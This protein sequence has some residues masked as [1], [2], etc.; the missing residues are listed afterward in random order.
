MD[1]VKQYDYSRCHICNIEIPKNTRLHLGY[2][3]RDHHSEWITEEY[4]K[5]FFYNNK[6]PLCKCGCQQETKW[7]KTKYKYSDYLWGHQSRDIEFKKIHEP[8]RLL[9]LKNKKSKHKKY[10]ECI[11][12]INSTAKT[13]QTGAQCENQKIYDCKTKTMIA[14]SRYEDIAP[15]VKK[16]HYAKYIGG[17][18]NICF[19]WYDSNDELYA[20]AIYGFP[21]NNHN[22]IS[23]LRNIVKDANIRKNNT[24]ELRRLCR[25]EPKTDSM[26]LTKFISRC[27][28]LLKLHRG[29]HYILSFSDPEYSHSGGI[30]RAANFQH[31]GKS[32]S[33]N[34]VQDQDGN[35]RHSRFVY[36]YAKKNSMSM[37]E[38]L[39]VMQCTRYKTA[40]KDR[41]FIK[42]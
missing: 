35:I 17:S 12:D 5:Q 30:Y 39:E 32:N 10:L 18:G 16:W 15:F 4:Y 25:R 7:Q 11:S 21:T 26:P 3:L 14:I 33:N 38:A 31:I 36:Q 42:T 6:I 29:I 41:W 22:Q 24:L 23:F 19:G 1:G 34:Y 13:K 28:K 20:A 37:N 2:H 40:D 27:H 9:A 8:Q